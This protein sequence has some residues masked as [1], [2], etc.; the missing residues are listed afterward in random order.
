MPTMTTSWSAAGR[1]RRTLEEPGIAM[2]PDMWLS[3][4]EGP[5]V[6]PQVIFG[7]DRTG[8]CTLSI[9][10]GLSALGF[11]SGQLVGQ[12][13]FEVYRGDPL[14]TE[15]L[16]RAL[17]GEVF[18][19]E[20]QYN[21]RRLALYF[22]PVLDDDGSVTGALGVATDVTEQRRAERTARAARLQAQQL[23]ELSA[24]LTLEVLDLPEL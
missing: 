24:V 13:L 17:A 22:E 16:T 1:A 15:A 4:E 20:R 2:T 10:S 19:G 23:A 21:G 18:R 6:G 3:T 11:S 5:D 8:V 14:G 7:L 12:D 9:G